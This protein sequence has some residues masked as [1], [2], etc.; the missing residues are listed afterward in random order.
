M[1]RDE[2]SYL[3]LRVGP[4]LL[5]L[6]AAFVHGVHPGGHDLGIP[7]CDLAALF[8]APPRPA[9]PFFVVTLGGSPLLALGCDG[10]GH[11][12][13]VSGKAVPLPRLGLLAPEVFEGA[14]R[15]EGR[16]LLVLAPAAVARRIR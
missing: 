3:D 5:A 14:V 9:A 15:H 7:S 16:L 11:L 12:R 1:S 13:G 10:V 4:Y 6:R 8:G 2:E